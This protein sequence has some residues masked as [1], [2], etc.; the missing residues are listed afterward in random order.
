M[1]GL[2]LRFWGLFCAS[3]VL[4]SSSAS[5]TGN[6]DRWRNRPLTV[7]TQ[8]LFIGADLDIILDPEPPTDQS[9]IPVR[10][11][12]FAAEIE[13][14]NFPGRAKALA[15]QVRQERP[16][17][18]GVQEAAWIR[19]GP[20]DFL[21]GN[22]APNADNTVVDFLEVL[23]A[24]LNAG[25]PRYRVVA[26][27]QNADIELPAFDLDGKYV[28]DVRLTDRDAIIVRD[29]LDVSNATNG[30]Y[31]AL[32]EL[33][34]NL[35]GTAFK[36]PIVRGYA[37]VDIVINGKKHLVANTHLA[38]K[39]DDPTIQ[40]DQ[41]AE[42]ISE[43]DSRNLPVILV[44]DFNDGPEVPDPI[45]CPTLPLPDPYEPLPYEQ[46]ICTAEFKD[47]WVERSN[48]YSTFDDPGYT[49][50]R[51]ERLDNPNSTLEKRIDL[52]LFRGNASDG[53]PDWQRVRTHV[54]GGRPLKPPIPT[55]I[56]WASDHAGLAAKLRKR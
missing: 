11:G 49:C 27:Q 53:I 46:L 43:L 37:T 39:G 52:I 32:R 33:E 9:P 18:I 7:M 16:D 5:A 41:A 4:F 26:E 25:R 40:A 15:R 2:R 38:N 12:L 17:V 35:G 20:G 55:D 51:N 19:S 24:E 56:Y 44:G 14:S 45:V 42:L 23:M 3:I 28:G 29:G 34:F 50:C 47:A 10:V 48:Y 21:A 6:F 31:N 36:L 1:A 13:K 22:P 54:I 8:N 30:T